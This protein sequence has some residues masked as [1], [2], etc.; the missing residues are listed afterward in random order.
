[1][2]AL[3]TTEWVVLA[4]MMVFMAV[5]SIVEDKDIRRK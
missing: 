5:M 3:T 2:E 4:V 1:M